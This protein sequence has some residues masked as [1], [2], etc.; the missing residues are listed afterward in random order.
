MDE[1]S[2][3]YQ[4]QLRWLLQKL[5]KLILENDSIEDTKAYCGKTVLKIN[6]FKD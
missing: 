4:E 6:L 1:I 3:S 5:F 2:V